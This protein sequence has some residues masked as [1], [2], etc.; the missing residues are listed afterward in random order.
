L[1]KLYLSKKAS[2][3]LR[4]EVTPQNTLATFYPLLKVL[5]FYEVFLSAIHMYPVAGKYAFEDK[6]KVNTKASKI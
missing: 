4:L 5:H 2:Q 1:Y 6:K 3:I